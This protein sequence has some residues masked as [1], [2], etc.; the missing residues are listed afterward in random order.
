MYHYDKEKYIELSHEYPNI[1][2]EQK[3]YV[4]PK[5]IILHAVVDVF[6]TN[7]STVIVESQYVPIRYGYHCGTRVHLSSTYGKIDYNPRFIWNG[8]EWYLNTHGTL[9]F[10]EIELNSEENNG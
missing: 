9:L 5:L 2:N 8:K 6:L 10:G 1:I 3:I 7:R 4:L